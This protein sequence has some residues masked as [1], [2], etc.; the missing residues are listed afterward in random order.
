[1]D[2]KISRKSWK[3]CHKFTEIKPLTTRCSKAMA[4]IIATSQGNTRLFM[5]KIEKK[6]SHYCN[7]HSKCDTPSKCNKKLVILDVNAQIA[8]KVLLLVQTDHCKQNEWMAFAELY[9]KYKFGYTTNN[10]EGAHSVRRKFAD[11][12]YQLFP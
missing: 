6:M 11:K 7:D 12:R 10:V 4:T 1:M 2:V 3:N 9:D 5:D 8:F